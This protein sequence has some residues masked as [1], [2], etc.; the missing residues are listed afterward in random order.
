MADHMTQE[1][2]R[3]H[4]VIERLGQREEK[5]QQVLM[6]AGRWQPGGLAVET[7]CRAVRLKVL[8]KPLRRESWR[9][10]RQVVLFGCLQEHGEWAI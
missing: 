7:K 3:D 5:G 4:R 2:S 8:A 10:R 6:R 9:G 1:D